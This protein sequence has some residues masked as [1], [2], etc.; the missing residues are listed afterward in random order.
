M[1]EG[2]GGSPSE[3]EDIIN[4]VIGTAG[5]IDH[6]KSLLVKRLTGIDP[7]RLQEEKKRGITIDLGFAPLVLAGGVRV[8]II[9]VPGHERF[10]KNMI[11][12]AT[13]IDLVLF[14]VAADDGVMPQTRE[15]VEIIDLLGVRRGVVALTKIDLV[16]DPQWLELVEEEIRELLD[17]TLLAGAPIV[18][19]SSVTGEGIDALRTILDAEIKRVKRKAS[20]GP[21]RLPIQRVFSKAG[22]GTVVTGVPLSGSLAPGDTLEILPTGERGRVKGVQ[23]YMRPIS[24][25][26]AGHSTAVNLA[27]VDYRRVRRGHVAAQPDVFTAVRFFEARLRV[28]A[29]TERRPLKHRTP[30]RLHVGTAEVLGRVL[31]LERERDRARALIRPGGSGLVQLALDEPVVIAP[32]DRFI[33]RRQSPMITLA[34]GVALS[35]SDTRLKPGRAKLLADLRAR[36]RCLDQPAALAAHILESRARPMSNSELARELA[37]DKREV[38][39]LAD[40]L[41]SSGRAVRL[42]DGKLLIAQSAVEA[43]L[44]KIQVTLQEFYTRNPH[45][46]SMDRLELRGALDLAADESDAI[47]AHLHETGRIRLAGQRVAL[48]DRRV[49]LTAQETALLERIEALFRER[50]FQP[51]SPAEAAD[52]LGADA[53]LVAGLIELLVEKKRLVQVSTAPHF[54]FHVEAMRRALTQID[55]LAAD[56]PFTASA[57]RQA[58]GTSRKYLIPLLEHFD[59]A[60]FT[61]RR[62]SERVRTGKK[63]PE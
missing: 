38:E 48:P 44:E 18:R 12:G 56:G 39:T 25:A 2:A 43:T 28:L 47:V 23:A 8:G 26:R 35:C 52:E 62:G 31:L 63:L 42:A 54:C 45:R 40:E 7:D 10:V 11:A 1:S 57:L 60:G 33:L 15:H 19:V 50:A 41:A 13:G 24:R 22:F 27:G 36:E 3:S 17:G 9:D 55:A 6:G 58:L 32:G 4:V 37:A 61:A 21:F 14:T 16:D 34:G 20:A 53:A 49:R 51:P 5:H 59:A 46:E 30:V 29:G